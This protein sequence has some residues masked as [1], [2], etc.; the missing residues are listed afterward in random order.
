MEKARRD[1]RVLFPQLRQNS[2]VL[3]VLG[4]VAH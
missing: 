2:D 4:K 3:I 1:E